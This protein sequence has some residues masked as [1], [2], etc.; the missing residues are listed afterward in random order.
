MQK[1]PKACQSKNPGFAMHREA[2]RAQ[3][4]KEQTQFRT[5]DIRTLDFGMAESCLFDC[6]VN[7][8][9]FGSGCVESM[10]KEMRFA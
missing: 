6:G 1:S 7:G 9:D 8:Q 10:A 2:T 4:I 5:L 3:T